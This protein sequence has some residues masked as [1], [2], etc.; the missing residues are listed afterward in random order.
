MLIIALNVKKKKREMVK[1]KVNEITKF[2]FVSFFLDDWVYY[3]SI[4]LQGDF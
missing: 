4:V 2:K 3:P 1:N